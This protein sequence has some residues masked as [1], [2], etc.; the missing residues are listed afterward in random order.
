MD[1][2]TP[3]D[4]IANEPQVEALCDDI[5]H[6]AGSGGT[7]QRIQGRKGSAL[8]VVVN[9]GNARLSSSSPASVT[10]VLVRSRKTRLRNPLRCSSPFRPAWSP[11]SGIE[12]R[13][14]VTDSSKFD[15]TKSPFRSTHQPPRDSRN[16]P[17][18]NLAWAPSADVGPIS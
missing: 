7:G 12:G 15:H 6:P 11:L 2:P 1:V 14:D 13:L 9:S 18:C 5:Y 8:T 3:G 16:R 17:C 4:A 10:W